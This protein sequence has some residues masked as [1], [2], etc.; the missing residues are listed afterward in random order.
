MVKHKK[1]K[2]KASNSKINE[3]KTELKSL[4]SE[5][6]IENENVSKVKEEIKELEQKRSTVGKGFKNFIAKANLAKQINDKRK[7]LT[8][9]EKLRNINKATQVEKALNEYEQARE[10]RL[11]QKKKANV[12]FDDLFNPKT[13]ETKGVKFEDL[14]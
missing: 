5:R 6:K 3:L 4:T 9:I 11:V 7:Y 12:S 8:N 1:V 14:Y 13:A 10:Q 2:H